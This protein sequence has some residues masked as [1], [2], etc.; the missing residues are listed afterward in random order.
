MKKLILIILLFHI[1]NFSNVL[2]QKQ[3]NLPEGWFRAGNNSSEF[4][5][6]IDYEVHQNGVRSIFIE[7]LNPGQK[8]FETVM[9]TIDA[10]NFLGKRLRL[11]GFIKCQDVKRSCSIWMRIDGANKE[12]LGF[13]NLYGRNANGNM[14]WKEFSI[15]L[16]IPT[17]SITINYG[18]MLSGKGKSWFDN[19][20]LSE[21]DNSVQVTNLNKEPILPDDPINLDFEK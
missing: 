2:A 12:N 4:K 14:D 5:A 17:N 15:V 18:V 11:T 10:I 13:D 7:S 19:L 8:E 20:S 6:G 21:V 3:Q 1:L 9:Q 16:D